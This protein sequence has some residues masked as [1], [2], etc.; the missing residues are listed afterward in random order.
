[1]TVRELDR[2]I[3]QALASGPKTAEEIHTAAEGRCTLYDVEAALR[4][5]VRNGWA[6]GSPTGLYRAVPVQPLETDDTE[7]AL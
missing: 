1:M 4:I 7:V 6:M 5:H 2:R 3:T